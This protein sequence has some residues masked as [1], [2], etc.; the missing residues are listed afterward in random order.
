[1][2]GRLGWTSLVIAGATLGVATGASAATRTC[3]PPGSQLS[4]ELTNGRSPQGGPETTEA[5][6]SAS[7]RVSR[8]DSARRLVKSMT[9]G[10]VDVPGVTP[11]FIPLST[12]TPTANGG[13][14]T[15]SFQYADLTTDPAALAGWNGAEGDALRAAVVPATPGTELV[16]PGEPLARAGIGACDDSRFLLWPGVWGGS[17]YGYRTKNGTFP[18]GNTTREAI[19]RAHHNWDDTDNDCGFS[20]VTPLFSDWLGTTTTGYHTTA[21]GV[22]TVDFGDMSNVG[23]SDSANVGI[24]SV[25]T[26]AGGLFSETDQRYNS[27]K[28]WS[29]AGA[30]GAYDVENIATHE[31]GHSIGVQGDYTSASHAE[32]TMYASA[33]TQETKKRSLGRG[34]VLAMRAKY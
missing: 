2:R 32:L 10:Y 29:T 18:N 13:W 7:Y 28:A 33:R 14:R 30:A 27:A 26:A 31:T 8:C 11:G 16:A 9:V 34:D 17:R 19:T 23:G 15:T 5:L 22:S 21:D 20:D 4:E 12:T 25:W 6:E 3:V 1:M 24:T